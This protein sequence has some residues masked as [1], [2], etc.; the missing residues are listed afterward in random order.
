MSN[1]IYFL[2]G[3]KRQACI[4]GALTGILFLH[5]KKP[6]EEKTFIVQEG[7]YQHFTNQKNCIFKNIHDNK[8]WMSLQ[9]LFPNQIIPD[10]IKYDKK[11]YDDFVF[12]CFPE[13]GEKYTRLFNKW[14]T[15]P[16]VPTVLIDDETET[17]GK[18]INA[19]IPN[20]YR[21]GIFERDFYDVNKIEYNNPKDSENLLKVNVSIDK[22]KVKEFD[23]E[24]A[25]ISLPSWNL[26]NGKEIEP[27]KDIVEFII[28]ETPYKKPIIISGDNGHKKYFYENYGI[29]TTEYYEQIEVKPIQ[30]KGIKIVGKG[31][32]TAESLLKDF[33]YIQESKAPFVDFTALL[34]KYG[35]N[36]SK[37]GDFEKYLDWLNNHEICAMLVKE[38]KLLTYET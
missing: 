34:S 3:S 7:V 5:S 13:I 1:K 17:C 32:G 24:H 12:K 23:E 9:K 37:W 16:D 2:E 18:K 4:T 33:L 29:K 14:N 8:R 15:S 28:S 19:H 11:E 38:K 22:E 25:F 35:Y 27:L 20:S 30:N 36:Y 10:N 6:D 31:K 21:Q 26:V